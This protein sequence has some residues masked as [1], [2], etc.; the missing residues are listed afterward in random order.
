MFRTQLF[1]EF[2]EHLVHEEEEASTNAFPGAGGV[3]PESVP[4]VLDSQRDPEILRLALGDHLLEVVPLLPVTRSRSAWVWDDTP[5][6][7]RSL[8]NLF[9]RLA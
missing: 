2:D 1:E 8:M 4:G 9:R 7:P 3:G 5:L 6:S